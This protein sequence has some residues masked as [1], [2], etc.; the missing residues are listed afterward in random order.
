M[1]LKSLAAGVA[2]AVLAAMP[3]VAQQAPAAFTDAQKAAINAMIKDYLL[4]NPEVIQEAMTELD[5]RQKEAE[6][7]SR[8][9]LV[10]DKASPLFTAKHNVPFGNPKG[11]VTIVEFFDY[12][13]GFC[14][15]SLADLQKFISED[16]NI[17]IITKDFPVLGPES[18][19]AATVAMAARQ[20]LSPEK[21]LSFHAKLLS[22]RGKVGRQQA[23][24]AAKEAGAD[25]TRLQ[26]DME[27]P[28]IGQ[29][30]EQN[31]QLADALGLTGT[32]S[33]I[34]GD[35]VVVGAVGFPELK[36]R[37]DNVRKCGKAAC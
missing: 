8:A 10:S 1:T 20:Q 4:K 36:T 24:D 37:V 9:K 34:V 18:V 5:R 25:M 28:E 35:D 17:R 7:E 15:R 26:K 31:V 22:N 30:I 14:R 33:Y 32:P 13:C 11:D 21:M 29:A 3:S 12:N 23:L 19:E 6:R 27:S 16:K 2:L